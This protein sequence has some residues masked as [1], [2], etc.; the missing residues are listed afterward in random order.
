MS[1][2]LEVYDENGNTILDSNSRC[3]R[4]LGNINTTTATGSV[5]AP[6][7]EGSPFFFVM[8]AYVGIGNLSYGPNITISGNTL[9]WTYTSGSPN[10]NLTIVY[11][12][13]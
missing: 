6:F 1:F 13:Y 4:M 5:T 7:N 2:G 10:T 12:V 11:G 9:S 8:G 3:S